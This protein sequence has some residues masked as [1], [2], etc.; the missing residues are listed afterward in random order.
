MIVTFIQLGHK[1]VEL[2]SPKGSLNFKFWSYNAGQTNISNVHIY[3][4]L[5]TFYLALK[6][7]DREMEALSSRVE[8][9]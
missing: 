4:F 8:Q 3:L 2:V 6:D 7:H 1:L 5:F 9:A